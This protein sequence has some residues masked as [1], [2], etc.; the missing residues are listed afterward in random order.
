MRS[1]KPVCASPR[2]SEVSV[3]SECMYLAPQK[4]PCAVTLTFGN[5]AIKCNND[6]FLCELL[7][8]QFLLLFGNIIYGWRECVSECI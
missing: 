3:L 4:V 7:L 8:T 5:K 2:L 6:V 1:E